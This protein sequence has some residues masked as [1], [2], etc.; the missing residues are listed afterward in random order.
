MLGDTMLLDSYKL[1]LVDIR[2]A[3][4]DALH[5]LSISVRWPHRAEDWE[6]LRKVGRGHVIG[7]VVAVSDEEAVA[8]TA[9]LVAP[10]AG[11]FLR[12]DTRCAEEVFAEFLVTC[13]LA[14]Y[15]IVTSMSL[16]RRWVR[17]ATPDGEHPHSFALA[18]QALG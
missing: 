8:V 4:L 13:G 5:A 10:H 17:A 16:G 14:L 11:R 1:A 7:P 9:P 3:R 2:E 15:D 18:S 12:V 6:I